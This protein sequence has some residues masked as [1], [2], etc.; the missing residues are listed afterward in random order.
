MALAASYALDLWLE[1]EHRTQTRQLSGEI[2]NR[3]SGPVASV[4]SLL[5][6]LPVHSLASPASRLGQAAAAPS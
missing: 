6:S 2:L 1:Y 5:L 3:K 4:S